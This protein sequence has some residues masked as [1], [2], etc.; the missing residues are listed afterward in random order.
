MAVTQNTT[1]N[2]K[3]SRKSKIEC[4]G[5]RYD[6]HDYDSSGLTF[7]FHVDGKEVTFTPT[8]RDFFAT[9]Y[10]KGMLKELFPGFRII[11]SE[12]WDWS[13]P[14]PEEIVLEDFDVLC[15]GIYYR[16][17]FRVSGGHPDLLIGIEEEIDHDT[18]FE[19]LTETQRRVQAESPSVR[20]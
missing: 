19:I 17:C 5:H 16:F 13:R 20:E 12:R 18:L 8:S 2:R 6:R 11:E 1:I 9:M 14:V 7:F 3:R 15:S 10:Y 4:V